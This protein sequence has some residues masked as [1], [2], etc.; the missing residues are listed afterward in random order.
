MTSGAPGRLGGRSMDAGRKRYCVITPYYKEDAAMLNRCMDSVA[1]QTVPVEHILVADGFPQDWLSTKPVRHI[2]LDRSH[3]DFGN[4]GR[5]IG[6][7]VAIA[8]KYS[9]IAFLDADNWYDS[10]HVERCLATLDQNPGAIFAAAQR[11]FVR[12]DGSVMTKVRPAEVPYDEHIDTNCYFFLPRAYFLLHHW[13]TMPQELA[14]SG[15]HLFYL[16]L[17][18]R[19]PKPAVV[20]LPTV[21]YLCMIEQVYRQHGETP[22]PGARPTLNWHDRQAWLNSLSTEDLLLVKLLTGL[23]LKKRPAA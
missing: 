6:A 21:N 18:H 5:G 10:N 3:S 1:R 15:D 2:I 14:A 16:L 12:P 11:R 7:M 22:P 4:L 23:D 20:A 17:Y 19:V 9:G 8:E 13:C